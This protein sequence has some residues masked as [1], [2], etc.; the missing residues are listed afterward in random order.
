MFDRSNQWEIDLHG[1]YIA[2]A[3]EALQQRLQLLEQ[4]ASVLSIAPHPF[5]STLPAAAAG[6]A[7]TQAHT[8]PQTQAHVQA[9]ASGRTHAAFA[10]PSAASPQ[11]TRTLRVIVGRGNR[12]SGEE[13]SL[14]RAVGAWLEERGL[15]HRLAG[16]AI[17]V[18]VRRAGS[19]PRTPGF[20]NEAPAV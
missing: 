7:F 11:R 13:A 10:V 5:G 20:A 15:R 16:G 4:R 9:H 8:H 19:A 6:E 18:A 12:S 14:P 17:E 3:I 1:L 2:E